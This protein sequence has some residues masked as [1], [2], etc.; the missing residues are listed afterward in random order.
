MNEFPPARQRGLFI[1]V[2][3]VILLSVVSFAALWVT[4]QIQVGLNFALFLLLFLVMAIPVP[5]LA[6]RAYALT[7]ANYMLDRNTLRLVWGLR[8]EDIPITDVEWVRPVK[9]LLAPISLPWFCLPGGI[10]GVT[11]Q[12]DIGKVE[13]LASDPEKL[14]LV[15]TPRQIFAISPENPA[16]FSAAFQKAI[17]MG[18]LQ[19]ARSQ[20]QYPSFVVVR[21]WENPVVRYLWLAGAS[22][23]MG[24]LVWVTILIPRLPNVSLGFGINGAPLL[25]I[26]GSQLILLPL[27]S[28]LLFATGL[29]TGLF[30]FRVPQ[31]RIL[32][33]VLWISEVVTTLLFLIA[34]FFIMNTPL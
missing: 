22:L 14:V 30:F 32:S 6:Y 19:P 10:V 31:L 33:L 16:A 12:P 4:F 23:N 28:A 7:R 18:S 34:V 11:R 25:P 15:A 27:L 29:F 21:A 26:P 1:H 9:G 8:V 5:I 2:F 17:E 3:M 20:S 24:L 13:F